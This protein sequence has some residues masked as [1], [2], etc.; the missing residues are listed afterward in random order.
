MEFD[1]S[2]PVAAAVAP[3]FGPGWSETAAPTLSL[4]GAADGSTQFALAFGNDDV[5]VFT[6]AASPGQPLTY[7][8]ASMQGST[9]T[10]SMSGGQFVFR[11]AGGSTYTFEGFGSGVPLAQRGKLLSQTDASGNRLEYSFNTYGM[12]DTRK[13]FRSI[14]DFCG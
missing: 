1:P 5:R 8:R 3:A 14:G 4:H 10:L 13:S 9:D 11:T 12:T 2:R 7:Q 6:G